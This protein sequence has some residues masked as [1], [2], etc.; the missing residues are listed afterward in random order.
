MPFRDRREAGR[1]LA[2]RLEPFRALDPVVLALPRGGVPVAAEVATHLGA[3]LDV[4][5]VRKVGHPHQPELAVGA[6]GEG[7]VEVL[8]RRSLSRLGVTPA[9]LADTVA[10]EKA[11]LERRVRRYRGSRPRQPVRDRTVIVVDDGLATG[12]SAHAAI[13][14]L[15]RSGAAR[16]I[17]AVPVAPPDT[18]EAMGA[19]ADE[20]VCLETPARFRAVG[21]WYDDFGEVGDDEVARLLAA[22]GQSTTGSEEVSI[23]AGRVTIHG[24]LTV[25]GSAPALVVFA[26]GSGSSRHSPR[27][28]YVAGVLTEA[29]I[30]T[31][32]LD[33]LTAE[34]ERDRGNVFDVELLAAR[35]VAATTWSVGRFGAALQVAYFGASTGAAAALVAAAD[36]G[37]DVAAVVSRG[38]RPDLAGVRLAEVTAPTLLIVGGADHEVLEL[39]R[40]AAAQLVRCRHQLA[41]VPGATHLFEEQGA[42]DAVARAAAEWFVANLHVAV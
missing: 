12:A 15:R 3:P 30:G 41:V 5:V 7:G 33:L 8:E 17:L 40:R 18:V 13:E 9:A 38:G 2:V 4:L 1:R 16:V 32:L 29:G 22:S 10:R 6:L 42:L 36:L 37:D 27:N 19:V 34:E 14:V 11:E 20:V 35:L 23:P 26:H 25:P 39:N 24:T 28:Q 21:L 31:L